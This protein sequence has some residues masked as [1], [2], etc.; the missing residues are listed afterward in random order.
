MPS[1]S[2]REGSGIDGRAIAVAALAVLLVIVMVTALARLLSALNQTS[3]QPTRRAAQPPTLSD[4]DPVGLLHRYQ[5]AQAARLN[6]Y[7]WEDP[8]HT[9]AHIPIERAIQ[10]LP[11]H[12]ELQP[13]SP[14]PGTPAA[15]DAIDT[16]AAADAHAAH[17]GAQ[18][19]APPASRRDGRAGAAP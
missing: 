10:L 16:A 12:P 15:S 14:P 2:Q 19:P 4:P 18:V 7:G 6:G 17:L 5:A 1:Q 9:Y 11:R 3:I 8:A 13:R